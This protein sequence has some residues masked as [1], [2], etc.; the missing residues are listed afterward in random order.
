MGHLS[1]CSRI[2]MPSAV[3]AAP[4]LSAACAARVRVYDQY[5]TDYHRWNRGED[6][7]YRRYLGERHQNY[8]DYRR[9]NEAQ[10][11]DYWNWRHD[12]R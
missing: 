9:L 3:L 11:R 8:R 12:H 1:R 7:Y 10:Q 2:L 4:L 5:H 6:R